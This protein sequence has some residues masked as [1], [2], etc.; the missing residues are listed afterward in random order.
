MVPKSNKGIVL[1]GDEGREK[2]EEEGQRKKDKGQEG[3]QEKGVEG[4]AASPCLDLILKEVP[5]RKRGLPEQS[6]EP[7]LKKARTVKEGQST[8]KEVPD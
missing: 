3:A 1:G 6:P 2:V 8:F 4:A 5:E 7:P